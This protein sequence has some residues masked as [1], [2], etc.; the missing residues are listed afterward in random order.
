MM[1]FKKAV[2]IKVSDTQFD[3]KYWAELDDLVEQK[4]SLDRSDPKLITEL[5]DCDCLLLGFQVPIG[6]EILDAAPNL[7]LINILATAYGTVDLAAAAERGIPVCNLG[8]YSTESVAEFTIAAILEHIR[9]LEIGKQRGRAKNYSEDGIAAREIKGAVFGVVGLGSIGKRVAE[10][11][12][13][14]GADVRYW[15]RSKKDSPFIYEDINTLLGHA[16]F[17]SINLAQTKDTEKFFN[18]EKINNLKKGSVIANTAPMELI[19]I[20]ALANRLKKQDMTFILDHSDEMTAEDLDKISLYENCIFY[21]PMAY[22]TEE[23][24]N[25]KKQMFVGNIQSFLDGTPKNLV[26]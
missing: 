25:S 17:L 7:K 20:D 12:G 10:L 11:A 5:K 6:K 19:D 16:D 3:E 4:I 24:R 14:F 13:G 8:G 26:V 21:P 18:A 22:I 2:L 23:A 1:K 9:G 15:S